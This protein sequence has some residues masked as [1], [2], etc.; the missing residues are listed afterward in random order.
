MKTKV[1]KHLQKHIGE[2]ISGEELS[3]DLGV[4]RTAVWKAIHQLKEEGYEIES[5][6]RRGHRLVQIPDV[7]TEIEIQRNLHT[8]TLGKE[9]L[10]LEST[11]STNDVVKQKALDGAKEGFLAI[12]EEQTKGKGRLGRPWTS[13]K[14]TG[15]WMSLLLRPPIP[16]LDTVKLTLLAGV[17]VCEALREETGLEVEIKWP[18]DIVLHGK[19][20]CGI[21]TE[22]GSE[23]DM[24]NYVILGI[25]INVNQDE[26]PE[27]ISAVGTSLRIE[28]R[29]EY[30]RSELIQRILERFEIYYEAF[31]QE[32][33]LKNVK[34]KIEKY[35]ALLNKMVRVIHHNKEEVGKAIEITEDGILLVQKENGQV[36][37]VHSGEVSVRGLHGYV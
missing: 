15:I 5:I 20:I 24:V 22:L 11:T 34:G 33:T 27:G 17:A 10:F 16:P 26:F 29:K 37:S 6:S 18:N 4:S 7:V 19:K 3:K 13:P 23:M 35:S 12:C 8:K 2:F 32:P 36:L 21:L 14:G 31:L 25:G 9:I 28:G 30:K 1:L